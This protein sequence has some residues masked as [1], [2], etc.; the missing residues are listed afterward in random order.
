[1]YCSGGKLNEKSVFSKFEKVS[2]FARQF[3]SCKLHNQQRISQSSVVYIQLCKKTVYCHCKSEFQL[4]RI[5]IFSSDSESS[6]SI[7]FQFFI[8]SQFFFFLLIFLFSLCDL[9]QKMAAHLFLSSYHQ[10]TIVTLF[11][12]LILDRISYCEDTDH[13]ECRKPFDCRL[14]NNLS[15]SFLGGGRFESCGYEGFELKCNAKKNIPFQL[16]IY[17]NS[18]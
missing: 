13:T 8:L 11:F 16:V 17:H 18:V 6:H 10:Y 9:S 3:V 4:I 1:M 15:Y 5:S 12:I 14:L 7:S 2:S